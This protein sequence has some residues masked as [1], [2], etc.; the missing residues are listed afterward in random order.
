MNPK[1]IA[2]LAL[3]SII[4]PVRWDQWGNYMR[5]LF[6]LGAIIAMSSISNA[7]AQSPQALNVSEWTSAREILEGAKANVAAGWSQGN[8][9]LSVIPRVHCMSTALEASFLEQRK[10]LVDFDYAKLA[11]NTAIDAPSAVPTFD[12]DPLSTPYWGRFYVYWNDAPGRTKEEVLE[13]LDRAIA[14]A[15]EQTQVAIAANKTE[16]DLMGFDQKS[17]QTLGLAKE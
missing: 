9:E 1:L 8:A 11:L 10:T 13:A 3:R 16:A 15:S 4:F 6:I 2:L 17:I 14:Y 12:G 7:V 5:K